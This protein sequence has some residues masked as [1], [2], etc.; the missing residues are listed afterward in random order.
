MMN[1]KLGMLDVGCWMLEAG[2]GLTAKLH[3]CMTARL[4]KLYKSKTR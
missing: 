1:Y 4:I 3:D 2:T